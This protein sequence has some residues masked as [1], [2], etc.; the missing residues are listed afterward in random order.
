MVFNVIQTHYLL[1]FS[2]IVYGSQVTDCLNLMQSFIS[3]LFIACQ[4]AMLVMSSRMDDHIWTIIRCFILY[5]FTGSGAWTPH[6]RDC[7]LGWRSKISVTNFT[8][9][10]VSILK[11]LNYFYGSTRLTFEPWVIQLEWQFSAFQQ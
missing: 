11:V 4:G 1:S 10:M 8:Y 3:E 9:F 2:S 5:R 7:C 6:R